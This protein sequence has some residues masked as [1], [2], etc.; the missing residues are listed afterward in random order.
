[1]FTAGVSPGQFITL[2]GTGLAPSLQINTSFPT[3]LNGVQVLVDGI[4]APL[5]YVSS[6][7]I[8]AI[9][10]YSANTFA[11]ARFQVVNNGHTS[12]SMI[13]NVNLTTPGVFT[14]SANGLGDGA[15][16]HANGAF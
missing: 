8:A 12:N 2:Y 16:E 3:T 1:P 9:V 15:I 4:P 13:E 6:T 5:Y 14:F 11:L 10:P 7:Q